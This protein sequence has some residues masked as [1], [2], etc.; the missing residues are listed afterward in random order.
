MVD[1]GRASSDYTRRESSLPAQASSSDSIFS[2]PAKCVI[3]VHL[4]TAMRREVLTPHGVGLLPDV[5]YIAGRCD[6]TFHQ[7]NYISKSP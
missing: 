6:P 1:R 5:A 4:M 7:P 2:Y 3:E